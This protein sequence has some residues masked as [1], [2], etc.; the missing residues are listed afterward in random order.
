MSGSIHKLADTLGI[1]F[2]LPFTRADNLGSIMQHGIVP[3]ALTANKGIRAFTND[4]SRFDY[5]PKATCTSIG[6]PN[7][8]MF[9]KYRNADETSEWVVLAIKPAVLWTKPCAFCQRNAADGLVTKIP[10]AE[11]MTAAAFSAMYQE[12]G[13]ERSRPMTKRR[14]WCLTLSSRTSSWVL[15]ST[16]G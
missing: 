2:L 12:V 9:Y 13:G 15:R 11:R 14:Y 16:P 8:R 7:H 3:V 4:S 5:Q 6:F 10:I 1:Q